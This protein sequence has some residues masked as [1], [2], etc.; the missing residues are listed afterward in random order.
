MKRVNRK[1][2]CTRWCLQ[3]SIHFF[4]KE[5][6]KSGI[7]GS[8]F[9][10]SCFPDSNEA[11][12]T[13]GFRMNGPI[14]PVLPAQVAKFVLP[15]A[16]VR[17]QCY[18]WN[19]SS[20]STPPRNAMPTA[21]TNAAITFPYPFRGAGNAAHRLA[22]GPRG[23]TNETNHEGAQTPCSASVDAASRRVWTRR[24][25]SSTI[26]RTLRSRILQADREAT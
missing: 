10:L 20:N 17:R 18:S 11:R 15:L 1:S 12:P 6:R 16:P 14:R 23:P 26:G 3:N 19:R 24:N 25:A 21:T 4:Y 22:D 8:L 13:A 9:L 2:L 7:C 5:I